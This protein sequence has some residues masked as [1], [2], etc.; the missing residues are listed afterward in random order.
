MKRHDVKRTAPKPKLMAFKLCNR[1]ITFGVAIITAICMMATIVFSYNS[2]LEE[3]RLPS[4]VAKSPQRTILILNVMSQVTLFFLAELTT[5]VMEA[6]R[7]A[8]ACSGSGTSALTF[9]TLSHATSLLG[10]FYLSFRNSM[11]GGR[12]PR[13]QHRV[14]GAQRYTQMKLIN[15]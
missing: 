14:W 13:N 12:V 6:T 10:V 4:L 15:L 5:L 3:P 11:R 2:S 8:L 1:V 7:W 9:L